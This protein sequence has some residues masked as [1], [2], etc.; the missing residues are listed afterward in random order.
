MNVCT[1]FSIKKTKQKKQHCASI[2]DVESFLKSK[3]HSLKSCH[4]FCSHPKRDGCWLLVGKRLLT[5]SLV[6]TSNH[7]SLGQ[8]NPPAAE[9]QN[10]L[11][12]AVYSSASAPSDSQ[13]RRKKKKKTLWNTSWNSHIT[14]KPCSKT[15]IIKKPNICRFPRVPAFMFIAADS[16]R[17]QNAVTQ[18]L[19]LQ[20]A[21]SSRPTPR[22][23]TQQECVARRSDSW[24]A[25]NL[26]QVKQHMPCCKTNWSN[27]LS[28]FFFWRGGGAK[29]W[30]RMP[31]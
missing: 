3:I 10:F 13:L 14:P 28:F 4:R 1:G 19:P 8:E 7:Q 31:L 15:A 24:R 12:E 17:D 6:D 21:S 25:V 5:L 26:I 16:N 30:A 2:L 22:R 23:N 20:I 29:R 27:P 9:D 11:K 18:A